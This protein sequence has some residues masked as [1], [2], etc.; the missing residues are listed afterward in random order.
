M[1]ILFINPVPP[2]CGVHQ[3]GQRLFGI[4]VESV[5]FNAS[6]STTDT[7]DSFSIPD[8]V[9]YNW[10]PI[11]DPPCEVIQRPRFSLCKKVIVYHDGS[12]PAHHDRVLFSYPD[13]RCGDPRWHMIG[14]P[15]PEWIPCSPPAGDR[16]VVGI[17][18]FCGAWAGDSVRHVLSEYE[19]VHFRLLLPYSD[20]CD[21]G[22]DTARSTAEYCQSLM[23]T[24]DTLEVEHGFLTEQDMLAWLSCNHVNCYIRHSSPSLGISS[25]TD[26]ALAVRRP[27]AINRNPMFR[28]LF[29]VKPSICVEDLPLREIV[30]NGVEPLVEVYQRNE[31][32]VVLAELENVLLSL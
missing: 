19:S 4:L 6:Y 31:R 1:K 26:N 2:R 14:R 23:R 28:H 18:G 22:G 7:C 3:Y 29:H 17:A 10:H 12:I 11:I 16:L 9:V 20:W 8:V 15:L 27:L 30:R 25:A 13:G 5:R 32:K 24:G 21:A